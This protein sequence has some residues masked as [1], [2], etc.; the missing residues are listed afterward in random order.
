MILN[1]QILT[2]PKGGWVSGVIWRFVKMKLIAPTF[3]K[4]TYQNWDKIDLRKNKQFKT[5][6]KTCMVALFLTPNKIFPVIQWQTLSDQGGRESCSSGVRCSLIMQHATMVGAVGAVG[7][8][9]W[10]LLSEWFYTTELFLIQES[11][12]T[13]WNALS[14]QDWMNNLRRRFRQQ[15]PRTRMTWICKL[16][17]RVPEDSKTCFPFLW[18]LSDAQRFKAIWQQ[19]QK[20]KHG[21]FSGK[22][23]LQLQVSKHS[24]KSKNDP[25]VWF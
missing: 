18:N 12:Q 20:Q 8:L 7:S 4:R 5:E 9:F 15:S 25:A 22:L 17:S 10:N 14:T 11:I 19:T 23:N 2:K 16:Y 6:T 3:D 21:N 1:S 13:H 24:L